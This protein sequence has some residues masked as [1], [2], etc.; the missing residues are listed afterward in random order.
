M[1]IMKLISCV[2]YENSLG[3]ALLFI[4]TQ[5]RRIFYHSPVYLIIQDEKSLGLWG[6]YTGAS[7]EIPTQASQVTILEAGKCLF[8]GSV[9]LRTKWTI[10][11]TERLPEGKYLREMR[12]DY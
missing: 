11:P 1:T 7:L 2:V 8:L 6:P 5:G 12:I 9:F 10:F 4:S 3:C